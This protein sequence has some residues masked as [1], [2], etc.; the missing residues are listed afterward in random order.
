MWECRISP[1]KVV[2]IGNERREEWKKLLVN[3][4]ETVWKNR[5]NCLK[6]MWKGW[7]VREKVAQSGGKIC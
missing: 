5:K 7:G 4:E 2:G 3:A 6:V 1:V